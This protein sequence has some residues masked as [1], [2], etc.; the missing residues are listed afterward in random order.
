MW[1]DLGVAVARRRRRV[2]DIASAGVRRRSSFGRR[3]ITA[4]AADGDLVN[5]VVVDDELGLRHTLTLILGAE[6]H[7]TRA[8]ANGESA[9]EMLAQQD[10][11]LVLCDVRMPGIDGLTFLDR[12]REASGRALVIM[13][14]AYGDDDSA[15]DAI[16]RGA[17]DFLQKPFTLTD[18]AGKVRE[19]LDAP[20]KR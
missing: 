20:A 16:K 10:A 17:Y 15:L 9:L 6:G 3:A 8:A 2:P 1:H 7:E 11:D 4:G 18:L 19:V 12:Y 14:S 5:I 13:M